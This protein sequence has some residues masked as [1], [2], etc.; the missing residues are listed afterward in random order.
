MVG[1][2]EGVESE[3]LGRLRDCEQL[4][5]GRALLGFGEDSQLHGFN[6]R[7]VGIHQVR[8]EF[9]AAHPAPR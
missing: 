9:S 8:R 1:A 2:E 7:T 3:F 6:L 4:I 5:V